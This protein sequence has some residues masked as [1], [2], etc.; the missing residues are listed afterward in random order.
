MGPGRT[1]VYVS[2][3]GIDTSQ[4]EGLLDQLGGLNQLWRFSS[5]VTLWVT[6]T[7]LGGD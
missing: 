3:C 4:K 1:W 7:R 2:F 6:L 5:P